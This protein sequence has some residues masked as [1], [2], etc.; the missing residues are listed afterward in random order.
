MAL[1]LPD[2][3][4]RACLCLWISSWFFKPHGSPGPED[5]ETETGRLTLGQGAAEADSSTDQKAAKKTA[6]GETDTGQ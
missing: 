3:G 6:A 2:V 4:L 5:E 1:V